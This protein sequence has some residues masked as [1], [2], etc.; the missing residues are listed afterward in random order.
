MAT[1]KVKSAVVRA[2]NGNGAPRG[3]VDSGEKEFENLLR[4]MFVF[5][6]HRWAKGAFEAKVIDKMPSNEER[7][8][9]IEDLVA[10]W[11][12]PI[13]TTLEAAVETFL[14]QAVDEEDEVECPACGE[15]L[16]LPEDYD[17]GDIECPECK[18]VFDPDEEG[19]DDP[20][21]GEPKVPDEVIDAE[22]VE[23]KPPQ[24]ARRRA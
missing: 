20:D 13:E 9:V 23:V 1:K 7:K 3:R 12:C 8:E 4:Q 6:V 16:E 15:M 24:A 14:S 22:I 2:T 10:M 11:A 17:A 21:G 19:D 5:C 18:H